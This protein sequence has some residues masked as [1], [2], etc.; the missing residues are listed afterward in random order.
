MAEARAARPVPPQSYA[1]Y[2][3]PGRIGMRIG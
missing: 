3:G 1:E 2:T